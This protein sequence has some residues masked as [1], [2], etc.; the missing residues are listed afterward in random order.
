[1]RSVVITGASSGLGASLARAY[2]EPGV[3]LGL[4][5]RRADRLAE[6]ARACRA[7]GAEVVVLVA[8]VADTETMNQWLTEFDEKHPIDI[9]VANA[10]T[11]AGPAGGEPTEG[12]E[13]AIRQI[14]TNLLG[15]INTVEPIAPRLAARKRGRIAVIASIAGLRGL[16]DSPTYSATKAGIRAYGEALRAR[17]A[18]RHVSVTVVCPGFFDTPM[19]DRFKGST[20]FLHSLE[21]TTAMVKRALDRGDARMSFPWPLVLALRFLDLAPGRLSDLLIKTMRF[22]IVSE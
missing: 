11:S 22:H 3:C 20:P 17:L 4:V 14:R 6:I 19:T 16:P 2:A 1:M 7:Q 9:L 12:L 21:R 5:A 18:P 8:D 15:V 13:R 10:G